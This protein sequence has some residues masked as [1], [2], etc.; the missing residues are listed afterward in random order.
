MFHKMSFLLLLLVP[1]V[2]ADV[3]G[4][5]F[6]RV[7]TLYAA[8]QTTLNETAVSSLI[9]QLEE[10][11][12]CGNKTCEKCLK[13]QYL[14]DVVNKTSEKQMDAHGY[15]QL[16]EPLLYYISDPH[17]ACS[18][19]NQGDLMTKAHIFINETK[20]TDIQETTLNFLESVA[21]TYQ[22]TKKPCINNQH[23]LN[24]TSDIGELPAALLT[25]VLEGSCLNTLPLPK[26]F[27]GYIY[28][29]LANGSTILHL[30]GLIKL[31]TNLSLVTEDHDHDHEEDTD[32]DHDEG[33]DHEADTDHEVETDHEEDHDHENHEAH[34]QT[35]HRRKRSLAKANTLHEDH[36]DQ[37]CF[38]PEDI[39][40]IYGM[41]TEEGIPQE[42]FIEISPS[43]LQQQLSQAC[44]KAES[45]VD[46]GGKLTTAEKYIYGSIAT[47]I[48]CLCSLCGISILLVHIVY[49]CLT[50][51]HSILREFGCGILDWRCRVTSYS[52]APGPTRSQ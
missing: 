36:W 38:S 24:T 48:I 22:G 47:L 11:V 43:L 9:R 2:S 5:I 3:M 7:L 42:K 16:S 17:G 19:Y 31:M 26:Y 10:R 39:L 35:E 14:F 12:Q 8:G 40:T 49:S 29:H 41:N 6:A 46:I 45:V 37:T 13:T 28:R 25:T 15:L 33:T 51:R 52:P 34:N 23:L 20:T 1:T 50:V 32:H 21:P 30:E 44:A 18:A 4:D 27:V